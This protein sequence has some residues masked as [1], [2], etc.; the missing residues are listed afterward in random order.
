MTQDQ[1]ILLLDLRDSQERGAASMS[2]NQ[3]LTI[4]NELHQQG[5]IDKVPYGP[6]FYRI[7]QKGLAALKKAMHPS[8]SDRIVSRGLAAREGNMIVE[9][10][11]KQDGK[12]EEVKRALEK[13]NHRLA[14]LRETSK[15][16]NRMRYDD[17]RGID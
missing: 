1:I 4:A 3:R 2:C 16:L 11:R 13:V 7:N 9:V 15:Q 8:F 17:T 12:T 10:G 14:E 6:S 5:L